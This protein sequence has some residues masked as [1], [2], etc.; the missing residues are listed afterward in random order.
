MLV[1]DLSIKT[2]LPIEFINLLPAVC[3]DCGSDMQISDTLRELSCT[4]LYC[5]GKAS[6]R[7]VSFLQDIGVKNM[8]ES[9]CIDVINTFNVTNP[10]FLFHYNLDEYET[11]GNMSE[12]FCQDIIDQM[13]EHNSMML[14]EYVKYA[15]LPYLRDS[16]RN[17]FSDYNDLEVFY[18]D[19][20]DEGIDLI[21][22]KLGIKNTENEVSTRALNIYTTLIQYKDE[23]FEYIDDV[24]IIKP[25]R[26]FN[27][28]ISTS[29]GGNYS[30]KADF[31]N[32][33]NTAYADKC[34]INFLSS[35]TKDVDYVIWSGVGGATSKVK[36]AEKYGIPIVNGTEFENILKDL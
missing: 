8:G 5:W 21:Q 29:V 36:K 27:I 18:D 25:N 32:K 14:W 35:V 9:R 24:N 3:P 13:Y 26:T 30:S 10:F 16:A 22:T 6:Q 2:D 1:K 4:N 17:I 23:L 20:E 12:E 28:C 19:L 7:M 11:I 34:H 31:V 15:N 33:M